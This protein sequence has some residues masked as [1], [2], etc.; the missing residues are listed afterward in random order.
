MN[1]E[2]RLIGAILHVAGNNLFLKKIIPQPTTLVLLRSLYPT[3]NWKRVSFYEGLPWFTPAVA[4]YVTA[5]ALPDFYSIGRYCIYLRKWDESRVQCLADLMHEG[6][7][8]LQAMQF[9]KGYGL[10]FLRIWMVY[11]IACFFKSGYHHNPFEIPAYD[12]EYRFLEY[13][14]R[15]GLH[16]I[17]PKADRSEL[18]NVACTPALIFKKISFKYTGTNS[19]F[20]TSFLLCFLITFVKPLADLLVWIFWLLST[21]KRFKK[22]HLR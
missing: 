15:N 13:C 11:Y 1:K 10:G 2:F 16:G 9:R 19:A 12:Q 8:V 3:V 5:Q 20:F 21:G 22:R 18:L 17:Q 6:F 4:P 14:A 7:H